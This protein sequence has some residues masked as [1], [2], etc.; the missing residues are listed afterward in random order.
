MDGLSFLIQ[1]AS[2]ISLSALSFAWSIIDDASKGLGVGG[3]LS[4]E[5]TSLNWHLLIERYANVL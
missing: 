5:Q 4:S 1:T 3:V 2:L